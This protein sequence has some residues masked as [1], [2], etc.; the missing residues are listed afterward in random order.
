VMGMLAAW[1][2]AAP[3]TE[4]G[5]TGGGSIGTKSAGAGGG[6]GVGEK[7]SLQQMQGH[8]GGPAHA[9]APPRMAE[10]APNEDGAPPVAKVARVGEP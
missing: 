6:T 4:A 7:R 10:G 9:E 2:N 3:R 5:R 8:E 1:G